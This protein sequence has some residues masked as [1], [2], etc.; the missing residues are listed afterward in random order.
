MFD[1][2]PG[3]I[4]YSVLFPGVVKAW[5]RHKKQTDWFCVV[6]G[7]AKVALYDEKTK[8]FETHFM[9]ELNPKV[10]KIVPGIWHGY[11]ALGG[12]PCG[13]VYYMDKKFNPS[14]PDEERAEWNAFGYNWE[15][16]NK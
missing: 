8:K 14:E 9:G 1:V 5:H 12:K 15:V 16:E 11:T 2:V 7:N 3:Q 10:I 13:L 4:N 6:L